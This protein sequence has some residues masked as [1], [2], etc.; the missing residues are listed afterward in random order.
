MLSLDKK[1][2]VPLWQQ[3]KAALIRQ[4]LSKQF[5]EGD[6]FYS[7]SEL[8]DAY[9]VS[10]IT[11]RRVMREMAQEKYLLITPGKKAKVAVGIPGK[12]AP[13]LHKVAVFFY[14]PI[15]DGNI[16]YATM[17]WTSLIFSGLQECFLRKN[18]LWTMVPAT[19]AADA[20]DKFER[21]KTEH[22]AFVFLSSVI[23]KALQ[24][25]VPQLDMPYL[26]VQPA[27]QKCSVNFVAA[28]H[29]TASRK[30]AQMA[31]H[32]KYRSFLYLCSFFNDSVNKLRGFQEELLEGGVSPRQIHLASCGDLS[33]RAGKAA[34]LRFF[35][36]H[37]DTVQ[38]PLAVY[39]S[40]DYLALGALEACREL[41]LKVPGQVGI[42]G[43][44]G[45]KETADSDPPLT[46]IEIPMREMGRQVGLMIHEMLE[47]K[48]TMHPG[49]TLQVEVRD[50]GSL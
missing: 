8:A 49:V 37:G 18:L 24:E 41:G 16:E 43:G 15:A 34:L 31:I 33:Q 17:P 21:L 4:V 44:T 23:C 3:L 27:S 9:Q 13:P 32:K 46:T 1:S 39:G 25:K 5:K 29:Y 42:A 10:M 50:R 11:V 40:G 12:N 14:S 36:E 48:Q 38:L 22:Q 6:S 20:E 19:N 45:I 47:Q 7:L 30:I 2:K 28:D 35:A 26:F